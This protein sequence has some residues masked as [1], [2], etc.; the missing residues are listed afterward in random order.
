MVYANIMHFV[1]DDA[2][3]HTAVPL[4]DIIEDDTVEN[5]VILSDLESGM[6]KRSCLLCVMIVVLYKVL[7]VK[8][9][10]SSIM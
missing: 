2:I 3:Q 6:H 8:Y 10:Y 7:V 1:Q 5:V 4:V 9:Y